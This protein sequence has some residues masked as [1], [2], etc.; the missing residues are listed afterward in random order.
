MLKKRV[1]AAAALVA[2]IVVAV[3]GAQRWLSGTDIGCSTYVLIDLERSLAELAALEVESGQL[4]MNGSCETLLPE[5]STGLQAWPIS[6]NAP[7]NYDAILTFFDKEAIA[8]T[9][10]AGTIEMTEHR[11]RGYRGGE[12]CY[13]G[14]TV[15]DLESSSLS[16]PTEDLLE[17]GS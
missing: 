10:V 11:P 4:C 16:Q 2:A 14:Q 1:I 17:R 6:V 5:L 13:L 3:F 8:A 9:T 15:A 7:G 12:V